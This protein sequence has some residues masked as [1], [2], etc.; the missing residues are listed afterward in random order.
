LSAVAESPE[1]LG[2]ELFEGVAGRA[3]FEDGG[4]EV[5]ASRGSGVAVREK[6]VDVVVELAGGEPGMEF[7][8][9]VFESLVLKRVG[10]L[11]AGK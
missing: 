7:V 5:V 1:D 2:E 4:F 10:D 11:R 3:K 9:E 8:L 6:E